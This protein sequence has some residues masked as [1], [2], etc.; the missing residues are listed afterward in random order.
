MLVVVLNDGVTF[1]SLEGCRILWVDE[2]AKDTMNLE[3][4]VKA[5]VEQGQGAEL[6]KK[7]VRHL[8]STHILV[9]EEM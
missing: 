6:T 7:S 9:A 8:L 3:E 1:S 2:H 4:D 5:M